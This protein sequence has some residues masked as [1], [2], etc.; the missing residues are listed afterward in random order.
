MVEQQA[1]KKGYWLA[2]AG[3][4]VG[5][6]LAVIAFLILFLIIGF[7]AF[8]TASSGIGLRV[9]GRCDMGT[10]ASGADRVF[11]RDRRSPRDRS[12]RGSTFNRGVVDT[13]HG[14]RRF[15]RLGSDPDR[16][17]DGLRVTA[18]HPAVHHPLPCSLGCPVG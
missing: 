8:R 16:G 1:A 12:A 18:H 9:G 17:H 14:P 2:F 3:A 11:R 6:F 13:H 7:L 10:V 5:A 4:V 15:R